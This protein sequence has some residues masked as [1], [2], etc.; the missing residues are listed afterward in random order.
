MLPSIWS[1]GVSL[2]RSDIDPLYPN[3]MPPACSSAARIATAN[4]PCAALPP[5]TGPTRL[6]TTTRRRAVAAGDP[7]RG[8]IVAGVSP[9]LVSTTEPAS[10]A[11]GTPL[12]PLVELRAGHP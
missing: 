10:P 2:G 5:S 12:S 9:S 11:I 1:P 3:Q 4:P 7:T 6:E 8:A